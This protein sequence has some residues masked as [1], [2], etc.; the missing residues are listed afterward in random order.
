MASLDAPDWEKIVTTVAAA[1][2]VPDAPDWQRVVVGPGAVPVG[3]GGGTSALGRYAAFG[4]LGVSAEPLIFNG[5]V[6]HAGGNITL[7]AFAALATGTAKHFYTPLNT[8]SS[9]FT[10]N[11]NYVGI[12]DAGQATAGT[13]TLLASSAAGAAE[14]AWT[15]P[16]QV[17]VISLGTGA[18]LTGGQMYYMALLNNGANPAFYETTQSAVVQSNVFGTN[19]P[20]TCSTTATH[21]TLPGTIAFSATTRVVDAWLM[22]CGV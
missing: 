10:P 4:I 5:A 8:G 18:A 22:Y 14:A 1:G 7:Q 11:E 13:A 17:S 6:G 16:Q 12:Y 21:T 15:P 20:F 19:P 3:G 9:S 2:D